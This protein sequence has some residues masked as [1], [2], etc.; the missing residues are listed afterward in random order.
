ME[1]DR[2]F[3]PNSLCMAARPKEN[4]I[5]FPSYRKTAKVQ[6]CSVTMPCH[7][8]ACLRCAHSKPIQCL[9]KGVIRGLSSFGILSAFRSLSVLSKLDKAFF[10][11]CGTGCLHQSFYFEI[12]T[13]FKTIVQMQSS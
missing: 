10:W 4:L 2:S 13:T 9:F 12:D 11:P 7:P 3:W 5:R 6:K 8:I 1:S